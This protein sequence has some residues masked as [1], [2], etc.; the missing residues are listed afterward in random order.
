MSAFR[1]SGNN[2]ASS[3]GAPTDLGTLRI[4]DLSIPIRSSNDE[5]RL[6]LG[7]Y[8]EDEHASDGLLDWRAPWVA[9]EILW[10]CQKI[11]L[12]ELTRS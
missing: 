11:A 12:G 3:S 1:S 2:N 9:G 4:G 6:P 8:R 10:S 5:E 7:R